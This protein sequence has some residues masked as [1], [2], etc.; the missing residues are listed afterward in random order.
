VAGARFALNYPGNWG[1]YSID[2]CDGIVPIT[3][4]NGPGQLFEL[5]F[6]TCRTTQSTKIGRVVLNVKSRG[7]ITADQQ[8]TKRCNQAWEPTFGLGRIDLGLACELE[9]AIE[10]GFCSRSQMWVNPQA[11]NRVFI[12]GSDGSDSFTGVQMAPCISG[13]C[14]G[15]VTD[16]RAFGVHSNADW[17]VVSDLGGTPERHTY[18]VDYQVAGLPPGR[19][20]TGLENIDTIC[21]CRGDCVALDIQ[22]IQEVGGN[23]QPV[24]RIVPFGAEVSPVLFDGRGSFDLDGSQLSYHWDFGDGATA[25]G[26]TAFHGF[27]LGTH[28]V[29]LV[30]SDGQ[31]SSSPD[32]ITFEIFPP[33]GTV[34]IADPA[35][36][37]PASES[38]LSLEVVNP[39]TPGRDVM[40]FT[41][42]TAEWVRLEL[43]DVAGR[44]WQTLLEGNLPAG[45]HSI[46][47][48]DLEAGGL[49]PHSGVFMARLVDGHGNSVVSKLLLIK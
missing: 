35:P 11:F 27:P 20:Q 26:S 36:T 34:G 22:V 4:G 30:V 17:A 6:L 24:A 37:T 8:A 12:A 5:D 32:T 10:C 39:A 29:T 1:I 38:R 42:L 13:S 21:N 44:R 2:F 19:Y 48:A 45:L 28:T 33:M 43:F 25:T 18:R 41:L 9:P 7:S 46:D 23:R 15:G 49:P 3:I 14:T 16:C 40:R 31:L 47:Y